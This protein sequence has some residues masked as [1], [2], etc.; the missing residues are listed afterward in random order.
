LTFNLPTTHSIMMNAHMTR[1]ARRPGLVWSARIWGALPTLLACLLVSCATTGDPRQG[2]FF[3]WDE[4]QAKTRQQTLE[5]D[6]TTAQHRAATEQQRTAAL[7]T[8]RASLNAEASKLR[9]ELKRLLS[10]NQQL[11]AQ[12]RN[13]VQRQKLGTQET[14]RLRQV[15]ANNEPLHN[16][17]RAVPPHAGKAAL[18]PQVNAV[19]AQ[20]SRLH[21]EVM[22]L[23]QR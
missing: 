20:N 2:G 6:E 19:E 3:G 7:Q 11:E 14:E 13:L 4:A 21:R 5:Q 22:I 15:L 23:L 18:L 12:L 10:E 9:G 8:Q 16:T 17:A 1:P